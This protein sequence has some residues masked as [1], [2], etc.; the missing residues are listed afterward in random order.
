MSDV[1]QEWKSKVTLKDYVKI[2]F[3]RRDLLII[4]IVSIFLISMIGSFFM[5]RVYRASTIIKIEQKT[6]DLNPLDR[7]D[8]EK[9]QRFLRDILKTF[10]EELL[11]WGILTEV[12]NHPD[13]NMLRPAGRSV[14]AREKIINDV[15][16]NIK[17]SVRGMDVIHIEY[18]GE[19]RY[20]VFKIVDK[21]S[22]IYIEKSLAKQS[23]M[24]QSTI[25]FLQKRLRDSGDEMEVAER[26]LRR[27]KEENLLNLPDR[28]GSIMSNL[29]GAHSTMNQLEML[30]EQE[31]NKLAMVGKQL[32]GEEPV[33][34]TE[35]TKELNPIVNDLKTKQHNLELRLNSLLLQ[36]T[37]K[38]PDVVETRRAIETIKQQLSSEEILLTSAETSENN[39]IFQSLE[40]TQKELEQK[41]NSL[42]TRRG[43]IQS[44]IVDYEQKVKTLPKIEQTY[45]NLQREYKVSLST[46]ETLKKQLESKIIS[47]QIEMAEQGLRFT[48]IEPPRLPNFP[49]KPNHLKIA[50][51]G[52]MMGLFMSG[53]L[54]VLAEYS[55]HSFRTY[56]DAAEYLSMP[57]LGSVATIRTEADVY[58]NKQK[59][60]RKYVWVL[61]CFIAVLAASL[62][63][64]YMVTHK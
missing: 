21:L 52:L 34:V 60:R 10:R 47:Q 17:T 25:N 7:R 40:M 16:K 3:K 24:Y 61:L 54:V 45:A 41:L 38:H 8:A 30:I 46:Y 35:L 28:G 31:E 49:F 36:Y 4:P 12:L 43:Q 58:K 42:Y 57:I 63:V 53:S 37:D 64:I 20:K 11:S 50:V 32:S 29:S 23:E 9:S 48:R 59:S 1:M 19:D 26:R 18:Q 6:P 62:P 56:S 27:F 2:L 13:I 15:K 14:S 5:P 39:P 51:F 44:A 22:S 33:I 55:D